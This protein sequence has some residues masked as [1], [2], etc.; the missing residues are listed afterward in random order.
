VPI[1]PVAY[2]TPV[3]VIAV[4]VE[5]LVLRRRRGLRG[6]ERRD[7]LASIAMGA[8]YSVLMLGWRLVELGWLSWLWRVRLTDLGNRPLTW[9]VAIVGLDLLYYWE[10]R[11]SHEVR[12]L[13]AIHVNHHSSE[14]Y[15]L[16]TALRQ[17][18]TP[19]VTVLFWSPLVLLGVRPWIVLVAWGINLL[20]QFW[21]H[22]EAI[23]TLP[24]P[25]ELVMNTPSHHRA[26]HGSNA[27]YLDRNYGGILIVWDRVFGTFE[28]ET[29]PVIYGL[30]KNIHTFNPLRIAFHEWSAMLGDAAAAPRWGDKAN[31]LLRGPSWQPSPVQRETAITR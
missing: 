14:R 16:S 29:E 13:W 19:F 5:L 4:V 30:T 21:I 18:W 20:Y 12:A 11:A 6:Y 15:N 27:R 24:R 1:D 31:H 8:G 9:A 26:H 17:P 23:G 10:H 2:A 22:T 3:F 25:I 28:P 7:T